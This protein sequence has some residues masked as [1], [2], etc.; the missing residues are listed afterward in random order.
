M[1]A[2]RSETRGATTILPDEGNYWNT[3]GAAHYRAGEWDDARDALN[4]SM[5]LRNDSPSFDWF[6]LALVDHKLGNPADAREWYD[7]A[8]AWFRT[9][10]P[11]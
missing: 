2:T 6:F 5:K 4:R 7:K 10:G 9:I 1:H 11:Q 3:L 8:V